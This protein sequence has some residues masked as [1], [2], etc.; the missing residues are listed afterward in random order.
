MKKGF[1]TLLAIFLITYIIFINLD[2]ITSTYTSAVDSVNIYNASISPGLLKQYYGNNSIKKKEAES[3]IKKICLNNL[4]YSNWLNYLDYIDL[5]IFNS[6]VLPNSKNELIIALNL[7]K[8]LAVVCIFNSNDQSYNFTEKIE[9]LLPIET[10]K[11]IQIPDKE[12]NFLL[13]YQIA[14]ERLGAYFY[15]KF[16]EIFMYDTQGFKKKL[17][18]VVFYEEIFKSIWIDETAP[19]DEWNKNVIINS[20]VFIENANLHIDFSGARNKYK[21]YGFTNIPKSSDFKLIDRYSYQ[22]KYFWNK[23]LERFSRRKNNII[24]NNTPVSII[25]DSETDHKNLHGFSK[26]KYKLLTSSDRI[27]YIDKRLIDEQ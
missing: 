6:N 22:Y 16:L 27:L 15:E 9:N 2:H 10:I 21:A 1:V 5:K 4:G 23:E 12:Y 26:N 7:S 17:K 3:E 14:D 13:T 25:G 18:E 11:F 19:K 8:D 24:F 20:I